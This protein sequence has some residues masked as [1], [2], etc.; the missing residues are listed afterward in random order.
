[1][2]KRS[3]D[4]STDEPAAKHH[5]EPFRGLGREG[6]LQQRVHRRLHTQAAQLDDAGLQYL[7]ELS[8][9]EQFGAI[10]ELLPGSAPTD[11]GTLFDELGFQGFLQ[12]CVHRKLQPIAA[13]FTPEELLALG[14]LSFSEQFRSLDLPGPEAKGTAGRQAYRSSFAQERESLHPSVF[15][16]QGREGFL[17]HRVHR[18]LQ[19]QARSFSDAELAKFGGMSFKEQFTFLGVAGPKEQSGEMSNLFGEMGRTGYIQRRIHRR[20][21]DAIQGLA[22]ED[23]FALGQQS[24]NEQ[25]RTLGQDENVD[26]NG[27]PFG[28][29]SRES[30]IQIHVHRKLHG[31]VAKMSDEEVFNLGKLGFN[32]QFRTLSVDAT[33]ADEV[34]FQAGRAGY[35][36]QHIHRRLQSRAAQLSDKDLLDLGKLSFNEQFVVLQTP[37]PKEEEQQELFG[38]AGRDGY[39]Q[40]RIHRMLH[41]QVANMSD[42]DL[43]HLGELSFNEQFTAMGRPGPQQMDAMKSRHPSSTISGASEAGGIPFLRGLTRQDYMQQRIHRKLHGQ[44]AY[45]SDTE[46]FA[47]GELSFNEQFDKVEAVTAGKGQ[48]SPGKPSLART[49]V[50]PF[51][52][53]DRDTYMQQRV[54]RKLHSKAMHLSDEDL[55]QLG[56][57]SFNDQFPTIE[58]MALG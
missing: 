20:L 11:A 23:V 46:L 44:V 24:F 41:N 34:N 43:F 8:F 31:H 14:R 56:S 16:E 7:G 45:F 19:A 17:Q 33:E 38:D 40:Q 3:A 54:H 10:E 32:E 21:H 53:M 58:N 49:T 29:E 48:L 4:P 50:S 12:R 36:Q 2:L 25:F 30:Y 26:L 28:K 22:D 47:V 51:G 35:I 6:Y 37:G 39:L 27:N 42:R 1:M 52:G 5:A 18:M 55:K 13:R 57:L 9:N 15:G